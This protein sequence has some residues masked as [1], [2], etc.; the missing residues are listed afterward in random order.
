MFSIEKPWARG[1][2]YL[3]LNPPQPGPCSSVLCPWPQLAAPPTHTVTLNGCHL[4]DALVRLSCSSNLK[5]E[6]MF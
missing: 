2:P 6:S 4:S 5:R 3:N 1:N